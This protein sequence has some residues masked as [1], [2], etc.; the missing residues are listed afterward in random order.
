MEQLPLE[1]VGGE[2]RKKICLTCRE[3]KIVT[4]FPYHINRHGDEYE[5]R[6]KKCK[7]IRD[8]FVKEV[9]FYAPPKPEMCQ[10]PSCTRKAE[11][12]D[13]DPDIDDPIKAFRGWLC[14]HCNRS[15]GQLG[16]DIES[17]AGLHEYLKRHKERVGLI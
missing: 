4:E 2:T 10:R 14:H 3:E 7:K 12:C 17:V 16:D 13:H 5:N 11:A 15:L 6:C 8:S 1:L 9:K